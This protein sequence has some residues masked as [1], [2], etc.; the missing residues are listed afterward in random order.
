MRDGL[1]DRIVTQERRRPRNYRR[2]WEAVVDD[3]SAFRMALCPVFSSGGIEPLH[4]LPPARC[5]AIFGVCSVIAM[6]AI[7]EGARTKPRSVK[8]GALISSS[9]RSS[10]G[11][12]ATTATS[13]RG[14]VIEYG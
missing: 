8:T 9:A 11:R 12:P 7:G 5:W 3:G 13:G 2:W 6:L 14:S 4:K 10:L 1:I